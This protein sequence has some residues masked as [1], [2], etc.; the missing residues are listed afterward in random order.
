MPTPKTTPEKSQ[1]SQDKEKKPAPQVTKENDAARAK[2][3]ESTKKPEKPKKEPEKKQPEKTEKPQAAEK[4]PEPNTSN[5]PE[6]KEKNWHLVRGTLS[7][8]NTDGSMSSS[9]TG[10]GIENKKG[11]A[12]VL[13]GP[14][15]MAERG[16]S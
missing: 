9:T 8:E 3:A 12:Q 2:L 13:F 15:T 5:K 11:T 6:K 16:P 7:A 1:E 10:I 14:T 4:K